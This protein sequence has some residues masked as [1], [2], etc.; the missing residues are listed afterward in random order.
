[1]KKIIKIKRK[2]NAGKPMMST[3]KDALNPWVVVE[4]AKRANCEANK[5]T[6]PKKKPKRTK[7]Y[8]TKQRKIINK[9]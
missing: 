4:S 8:E 1:M 7:K 3:K 5:K 9:Y 2:W 6:K